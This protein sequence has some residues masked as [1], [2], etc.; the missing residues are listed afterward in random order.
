MLSVCI[1]EPGAGVVN[2]GR[3]QGIVPGRRE[4]M[5]DDSSSFAG[6][7]GRAMDGTNED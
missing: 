1:P 6:T 4:N 5:H 7:Y 2:T 3:G